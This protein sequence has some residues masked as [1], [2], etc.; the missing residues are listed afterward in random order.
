MDVE[1]LNVQ[2]CQEEHKQKQI[3]KDAPRKDLQVVEITETH[4]KEEVPRQNKNL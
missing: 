4:V 1:T 2:V 3:C